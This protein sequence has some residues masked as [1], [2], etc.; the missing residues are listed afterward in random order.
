M[1]NKTIK[2]GNCMKIKRILVLL[3]GIIIVGCACAI[4]LKAAIGVGAW[5]ALSQTTS[6]LTAIEV[7]TCGII[8]NTLCVFV[9]IF[10]LKKEFKKMQLCQIP[11]SILLGF[12]I[13]FILY[14]VLGNIVIEEYWIS[15]VLL[16]LGY[17]IS[18]FAVAMVMVLDIVT[19]ALE[20]ACMA[21]SKVTGKKF[22][23]LRQSVDVMAVI[24]CLIVAFSFQLP[25]AVRE[26]TVIGMLIFGPLLGIFMKILKPIFKKHDLIDYQ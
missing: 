7:G 26:G 19:F 23:V 13:N 16:I 15:V 21:V 5:D 18:A 11:L 3:M 17:L 9:Q 8:F 14:D 20:G 24:I 22:H 4:T 2:R 6:E 12:V 10:V 25:L 1:I